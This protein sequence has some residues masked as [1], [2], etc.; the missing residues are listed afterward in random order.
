MLKGL[1][2]FAAVILIG[3]LSESLLRKKLEIPKSKGFIYRGVSSAHRWTER[4]LLLIY[5][6]CLMIFDFSIGLFLAFIIPFFAFRTFMEWKYEKERKE[7][8]ITLHFVTV[9]PLLIAGG[10]LVNIL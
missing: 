2:F 4:I 1:V 9:F 3:T 10:Y 8:L 5:I 6:I 7:Y